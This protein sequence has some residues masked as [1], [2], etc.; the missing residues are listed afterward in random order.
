MAGRTLAAAGFMAGVTFT[1]QGCASCDADAL[2]ECVVDESAKIADAASAAVTADAAAPD[3]TALCAS[4]DTYFACYD[5]CCGE[6]G[7][8][9]ATAALVTAADTAYKCSGLTDPC[10]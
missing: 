1:P 4:Y 2:A 9:A 10:V 8:T 3:Y 5:G 7:M 6:E